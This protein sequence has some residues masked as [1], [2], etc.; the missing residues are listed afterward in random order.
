[1]RGIL[2]ERSSIEV[3][4][5]GLADERRGAGWQWSCTLRNDMAT[6]QA[7]TDHDQIREWV[8]SRGGHPSRVKRTGNRNDPGVLRIDFPGFSGE[9]TLEE[10]E[11]E[12]FF[13]WFDRDKLALLL[14][15]EEGNRFN[16]FVSRATAS[17]GANQSSSRRGVKSS[18]GGAKKASGS[19]KASSSKKAAGS[20]KKA[21]SAKKAAG[22]SKKASSKKAAGSTKRASGSTKKASTSSKKAST[23]SSK[24]SSSSSR[25]ASTSKKASS[26]K[27]GGS[28]KKATGSTKKASSAKRSSTTRRPVGST[29]RK[30]SSA[31]RASTRGGT[32]NTTTD[33]DE[34]RSWVEARGGFPAHVRQTGRKRGDL[35]VLRIDYP[36]YSG[37]D[38]LERIDWEDWFEAFERNKLA[39]LYQDKRNSRF[40]KLVNR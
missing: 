4:R 22:S 7:T 2:R 11:W 21:S 30:A 13:E 34:I 17:R 24:R 35:G 8:E 26:A 37:R 14:S 40:S 10:I 33:H 9:D 27:K 31:K 19:K 3:A 36:G 38:T 20:S 39:F 29:T 16:K 28:A 6:A 1:M 23:S 15:D 18:S 12:E 5:H 25:K 32:S